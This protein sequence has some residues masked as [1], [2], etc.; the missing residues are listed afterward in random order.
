MFL[1]LSDM[2]KSRTEIEGTRPDRYL[3][4]DLGNGYASYALADG[5]W[6]SINGTREEIMDIRWECQEK[7]RNQIVAILISRANLKHQN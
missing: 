2:N 3:E 5:R 7:E 4:A 1:A 6:F